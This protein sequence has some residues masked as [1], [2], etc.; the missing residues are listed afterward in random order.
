MPSDTPTVLHSDVPSIEPSVSASVVPSAL[1]SNTPT[2]LHSDV[3][4]IEPSTIP[5]KQPSTIPSD[6]PTV[7][8]SS[9]AVFESK[10]VNSD[11]ADNDW[12]GHVVA[13]DADTAVI[14]AYNDDDNGSESGSAYIYTHSGGSWA[15]QA[16]LIADDGAPDDKFGFALAI[17]GDTVV[18]GAYRDDDKGS[19]SGS[20]YVYTRSGTTWT[21]QAKLKASDGAA[22]D[23]FGA[24]VAI[25][26]DTIVVGAWG[27]DDNG[28][29]SGSAYI[30]T[31][32]GTTWSEQAKLT[33]SDGESD[34][35]FGQH[36][37]ISG[38][39]IV[40]G[41]DNDDDNGSASGSAYVFTGSGTMWN[42]QAKLIASDGAAFD[43][44]G[45]SVAIDGDTIVIGAWM[46]DDDGSM[47]GSA[48]IYTRSGTTWTEQVKLTAS[49]G[50]AGEMF[51]TSVAIGGDS[52][53]VGAQGATQGGDVSGGAYLFTR[54]GTTWTEHSKI[55]APDSAD[56]D[57]FGCSAAISGSKVLV[58]AFYDDD[59]GVNSG[60]AY[61]YNLPG[62]RRQL[63]ETS[64]H[65][66]VDSTMHLTRKPA[67]LEQGSIP[68][69][70]G[71]SIRNLQY[72]RRDLNNDGTLLSLILMGNFS[73]ASGPVAFGQE[74]EK[75]R[76]Y[77]GIKVG[78]YNIRPKEVNPETGK[79]AHEAFLISIWKEGVGWVEVP[80][81]SLVYR[82]GSTV[83]T[84]MY[85]RVWDGNYITP[86]VRAIGLGLMLMVWIIAAMSIA[87]LGWLRNDLVVQRAQPFFM[88]LLCIGSIITSTSIFTLSWDEDAGWSN[89]ELSIACSLTPWFF[90]TGHILIFCSL[91]IK[92][93]RVD[94]V[95]QFQSTAITVYR[96]LWPLV[97][98]LLV[99][100]LVLLAQILYDPWSW[101]RST[102]NEVPAETYG[103]CQSN[104][105][106]VFFGL[107]IGLIFV[108]EATTMYF[109]WKT[110]NLPGDFRDS[111]AVMYACMAQIQSWVVGVPMV[112]M[113]GHSS[114]DAIYFAR[115]LLI[116]IFAVSGVVVVVDPKIV[117]AIKNRMK[118]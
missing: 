101:K 100:L 108:A 59:M 50:G 7:I 63:T 112:A 68:A 80:G 31:R 90:F 77:D 28:S 93:W 61:I 75:G 98:F 82:D 118:P 9:S 11:G 72:K 45:Q 42:E 44:F 105:S 52:V 117:K 104:H 57:R 85:R 12:F 81:R 76:N 3:P 40:V 37:A 41:A 49:D 25:S 54:S 36:V 99:T 23:Y 46:D 113:L 70:A 66:D 86:S 92:L 94:R 20:A 38:N 8:L 53:I 83:F 96:A 19:N 17:G 91:F 13:L 16:K 14:G 110:V 26:G 103:S 69:Q 67:S 30:F 60:S 111:E 6:T 27:N 32:S 56:H 43:D 84:G 39:T 1:P 48:Y 5:S 114:A 78:V 47:S 4:S 97:G 51:G 74:Y 35:R 95:L 106:W 116:W 115:M 10:L 62:G 15:Q 29:A 71:G 55:T 109:A 22:F 79:R 21:Q 34:D 64:I 65:G 89:R 18:V 24:S 73:G 87:L 2:V 107:L 88:Q 33:A 58:G 102:I